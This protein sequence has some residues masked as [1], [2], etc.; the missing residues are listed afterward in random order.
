MK[1]FDI[2]M[3]V[4]ENIPVYGNKPGKG[5]VITTVNNH[6][7]GSMHESIITMNLHT[8][9]HI[10]A[11]LHMIKGGSTF[12]TIDISRLIT[13]CRV[14]DLTNVK[15]RITADDLKAKD[16]QPGS[17]I[18]LKTKNSYFDGFDPEFVYVD[19][20]G[21]EYLK[22]IG[23]SGVGIDNL[24]IERAQPGHETHKTLMGSGIIILEG[25]RLADVS[26]GTYQLIALPI[27][28]TGTEAAP[29]RAVLIGE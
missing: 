6:E 3:P 9:T 25:L 19:A 21:A 24:G 11:P 7:T 1:L 5:P 17:F 4:N 2:S 27:R 28:M 12:E 22:E 8:G 23:I 29:A 18:L 10:D 15:E 13:P 14:L 26:E 16:I 20:S